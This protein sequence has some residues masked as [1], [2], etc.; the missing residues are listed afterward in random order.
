MHL[1][2]IWGLH[3]LDAGEC[4]GRDDAGAVARLGA[5]GDERALGVRDLGV[6]FLRTPNA[7]VV[8]RIDE[9]GLA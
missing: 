3:E 2:V 5:P 4:A 1:K 9:G 6:G 7:K 8:E